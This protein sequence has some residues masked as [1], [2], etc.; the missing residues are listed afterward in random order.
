[1]PKENYE[2]KY[3]SRY[4]DTENSPLYPFGYGLSYTTFDYTNLTLSAEKIKKDQILT[5][6]V[7]LTN[8]GDVKGTET[9][10]LY[11]RDKVAIVSRPVKELV[12][13]KQVTL[14]AHESKELQFVLREEQLRYVHPDFS[15]TSDSGDFEI[16]VGT[17]SQDVQTTQ[18]TLTD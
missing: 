5:V 10:Q 1:M 6:S 3:V 7:T 15:F 2:E 14:E 11:I 12:D 8:T 13:F 16:M 18:F 17:N 4:L 9:A